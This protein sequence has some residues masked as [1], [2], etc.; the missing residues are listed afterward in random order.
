MWFILSQLLLWRSRMQL[1]EWNSRLKE[2][3]IRRKPERAVSSV[4]CQPCAQ[5]EGLVQNIPGGELDISFDYHWI[6]RK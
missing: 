6:F 3:S 4:Q 5:K 2:Y 1:A